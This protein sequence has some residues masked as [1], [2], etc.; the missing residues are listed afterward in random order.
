M[1]G[2]VRCVSPTLAQHRGIAGDLQETK[3]FGFCE[4]RHACIG[5]GRSSLRTPAART[6]LAAATRLKENALTTRALTLLA[7]LIGL[8]G[9]DI[10]LHVAAG[11]LEPI[12]L[13]S[14]AVICIG[15][16]AFVFAS[17]SSRLAIYVA[18]LVY[19]A[20]NAAFLFQNGLINPATNGLRL[21]LF[22]FVA[23]SLFLLSWL[24]RRPKA[25]Q[26]HR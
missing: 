5:R 3:Y 14:N 25:D 19:L 21:P 23:V 10:L 1:R 6:M 8:Q 13:A 24:A 18:G 11:Q 9:L 22:G 17:T 2:R 7:C 12:R 15:A 4:W 26:P 16:A 20:L